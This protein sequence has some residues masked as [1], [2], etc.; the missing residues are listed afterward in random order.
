MGLSHLHPEGAGSKPVFMACN[1]FTDAIIF[2]SKL[3]RDRSPR[4]SYKVLIK[5]LIFVKII[6]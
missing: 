6:V 4:P 1:E 2:V 5:N 3:L